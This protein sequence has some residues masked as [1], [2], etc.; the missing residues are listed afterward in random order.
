M[1]CSI[2][3]LAPEYGIEYA[4]WTFVTP[5]AKGPA[6]VTVLPAAV[7]CGDES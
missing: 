2:V 7:A 5:G 1:G 6:T 3:T 4:N